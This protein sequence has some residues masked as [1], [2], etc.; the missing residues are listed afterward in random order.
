MEELEKEAAIAKAKQE[1]L[2]A[3][4]QRAEQEYEAA[5]KDHD[6]AMA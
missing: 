5:R 2:K 6:E 3:N 1:Q 4:M